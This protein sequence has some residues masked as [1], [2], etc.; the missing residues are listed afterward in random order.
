VQPLLQLRT[1]TP[2]QLQEIE[3]DVASVGAVERRGVVG[4]VA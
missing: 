3:P 1:L 4:E 2:V